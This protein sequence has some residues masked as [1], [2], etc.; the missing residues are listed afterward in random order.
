MHARR[1]L[2]VVLIGVP[3]AT[4]A[5]ALPC[6]AQQPGTAA[7]PVRRISRILGVYDE[8]SGEPI[9][10]VRVGDLLSGTSALTTKTGTVALSF[11][12][13]GG[14]LVRLQKLGYQIQTMFVA[15]TPSDTAPLT[16]VLARV[17]E[18]PAVV[19][20]A[21]SNH[22]RSPAL[23]AFDERQRAGTGGYFIGDAE[24]RRLDASPVGNVVRRLP[25]M[26]LVEGAEAVWLLP[27]TRCNDGSHPG[28]PQVYLD[29][30]AWTPTVR[31]DAPHLGRKDLDGTAFNLNDFQVSELA[32]IEFY[33]DNTVIPAG[34]PQNARR[35]GALF[36][37]S[38]DR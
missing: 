5:A 23:R 13:D 14:G 15:I 25:G 28:P 35:C 2:S 22:L 11:L 20:Q 32:A 30:V 1:L 38:R 4:V 33:P 12:P 34:M 24:L 19:T 6:A 16:I 27:T 10:G 29:G 9:E 18:L 3:A 21:D 36:L 26:K 37:W 8:K 31:P 7:S 17:T